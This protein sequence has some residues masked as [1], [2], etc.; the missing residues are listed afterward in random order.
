MTYLGYSAGAGPDRFGS[1]RFL[2]PTERENFFG[3][4]TGIHIG[5]NFYHGEQG[6]AL[7]VGGSR[8]GKGTCLV[9]QNLL[10][11]SYEGSI[12]VID[13]KGEYAAMTAR[14]RKTVLKNN[15]H[16]IDP[17]GLQS[18]SKITHS[19]PSSCFN[20][21]D[22]L[23]S[24]SRDLPDDCDMI[25]ELILPVNS[26]E[27]DSHFSDK[28]RQLISAYLLHIVCSGLENTLYNL[29]RELRKP[30]SG[31]LE[32]LKKMT[33]SDH[34]FHGEIIRDNGHELYSFI[35]RGERE[36]GSVYSTAHRA[37]DSFKSWALKEGTAKSDFEMKDI[38]ADQHV[39]YICIP[40]NR[41]AT[42]YGWLR[43]MVGNIITTIQNHSKNRVL[44]ILEEFHVLGHMRLIESSMALMAG[45]NLQLLPVVQDL[46][47]LKKNYHEGW[48]SFI[49]N[50]AIQCF[51]G[52]EDIFTAEYVSRKLGVK[53]ESFA[54]RQSDKSG[55][56]TQFWQRPLRTIDEVMNTQYITVFS[57]KAAPFM[58]TKTPFFLERELRG[59]YD[60]NPYLSTPQTH[61]EQILEAN[62]RANKLK[63]GQ[64]MDFPEYGFS[65]ERNKEGLVEKELSVAKDDRIK[66]ERYPHKKKAIIWAIAVL[67]IMV[68]VIIWLDIGVKTN[69]II[70]G[71]MYAVLGIPLFLYYARTGDWNATNP[72]R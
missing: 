26:K 13:P 37:T 66:W 29:R 30:L 45:Y 41:L 64:S 68:S 6:H 70:Y 3:G 25:A 44:M 12:V 59:R 67:I 52:I 17:W 51:L 15:V 58:T 27:S 72:E 18:N 31:T 23:K 48:E 50:T 28:A 35:E 39:I 16:I 7:V 21:L 46:N 61:D 49:A 65:L 33:Q 36:A 10:S 43:L 55:N 42:H 63:K 40:P 53:T 47:Q 62:E 38:T 57:S 32:L 2:D 60:P 56:E 22:I 71:I 34:S 54:K 8:S 1:A 4:W 24:D 69:L 5:G 20:P 11:N 19:I 14:Y 9:M